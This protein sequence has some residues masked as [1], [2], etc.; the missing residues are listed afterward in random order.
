[1]SRVFLKEKSGV[2]TYISMVFMLVG[3]VFV[4]KPPFIFG[5][6]EGNYIQPTYIYIYVYIIY[7]KKGICIL[8]SLYIK[9]G[10][11]RPFS[12]KS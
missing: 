2:A 11:F 1:M 4:I 7:G 5:I 9:Q 10:R 12:S 6:E 3:I 8:Y